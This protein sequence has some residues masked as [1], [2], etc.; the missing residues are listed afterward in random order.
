MRR[1]DEALAKLTN[2]RDTLAK[3]NK[4]LAEQAEDEAEKHAAAQKI[5]E[6]SK[7]PKRNSRKRF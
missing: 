6:G 1:Q 4:I 7:T 5:I 2:E 3:E